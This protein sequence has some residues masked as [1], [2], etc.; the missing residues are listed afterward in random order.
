MLQCFALHLF[1]LLRHLARPLPHP[2]HPPLPP[3]PAPLPRP[4]PPPLQV[5]L[6]IQ[7]EQRDAMHAELAGAIFKEAVSDAMA[8]G[9]DAFSTVDR[10][11]VQASFLDLKMERPA[12]RA[13]LDDVARK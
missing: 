12:A 6:C 8:A 1:A 7:N 9:I 4:L 3:C 11:R 13:V 2:S 5:Q 10:Q